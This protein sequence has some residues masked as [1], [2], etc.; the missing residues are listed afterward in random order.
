MYL[1]LAMSMM[2]SSCQKLAPQRSLE[3]AITLAEVPEARTSDAVYY[4]MVS[5]ED[6]EARTEEPQN[7]TGGT[8]V[9]KIST[10]IIKNAHVRFHVKDVDV[11]HTK[12]AALLKQYNAYFGSDN[13]STSV[14]QMENEMIIRV[15]SASFEKLMD[16]LLKESIYTN[17]KN[18][19]AQDVTAE[20][21]DLEA[22]LKTK[23]EVEERY[24]ALLKQANK[25]PD[26]LEVEKQLGTIREEIEAS[27]GR[28]KLLK[29]Q[30][31]YSTINLNTYQKLDYRP[32]PQI[33]FFSKLSEAFVSG[34]RTSV[35][36]FLE[37]IRVWPLVILLGIL[38]ILAVRRFRRWKRG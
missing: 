14:S 30:V 8:T 24:R 22:R 32:E 11:S 28:L 19:S 29:D 16:E 21:V 38:L 5:G 20:F 2:L 36:A 12:M 7:V 25:V 9:T 18:I 34:W 17:Y 26:I 33:G 6:K 4:D 3:T 35:D 27:E 10:R 37:L 31:S 1:M 13:R 23:K 15:P